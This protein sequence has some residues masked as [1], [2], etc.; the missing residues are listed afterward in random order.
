MNFFGQFLIS[1][2]G[3]PFNMGRYRLYRGCTKQ[4]VYL[5]LPGFAD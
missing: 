1:I 4:V 2:Y 3:L 5:I